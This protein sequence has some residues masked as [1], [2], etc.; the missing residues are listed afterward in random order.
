MWFN[1]AEAQKIFVE[2]MSEE[3]TKWMGGFENDWQGTS[4]APTH[5]SLIAREGMDG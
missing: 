2:S 4:L 5:V 1:I 3:L